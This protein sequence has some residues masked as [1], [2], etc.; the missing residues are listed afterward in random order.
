MSP[1]YWVSYVCDLGIS[2]QKREY[3]IGERG[4][5]WE[6]A[7]EIYI[8][9]TIEIEIGGNDAVSCVD[10]G[11]KKNNNL[12]KQDCTW[13]VLVKICVEFGEEYCCRWK[14]GRFVLRL[15]FPGI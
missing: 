8:K 15:S 7:A 3:S 6:T 12:Q 13:S 9:S 11:V 1:A 10:F 14:I 2:L 4:E 5:P